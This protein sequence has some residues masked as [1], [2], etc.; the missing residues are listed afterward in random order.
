M[1]W[2]WK[3]IKQARKVKPMFKLEYQT[4]TM[5][6]PRLFV[7]EY[8]EEKYQDREIEYVNEFSGQVLTIN[9]DKIEYTITS[10]LKVNEN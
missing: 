3:L 6:E 5:L 9:K 1:I 8:C 4:S 7:Y 10:P 2:L